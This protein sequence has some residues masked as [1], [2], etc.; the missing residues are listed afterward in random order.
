MDELSMHINDLH[1]Q[2]LWQNLGDQNTF[3]L[4]KLAN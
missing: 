4:H 2:N 1:G 3:V